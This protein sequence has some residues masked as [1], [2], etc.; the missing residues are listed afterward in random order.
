LQEL[1]KRKSEISVGQCCKL[2]LLYGRIGDQE[3]CLKYYAQ[4]KKGTD[5]E[6]WPVI[7]TIVPTVLQ[8]FASDRKGQ[9]EWLRQFFKDFPL[10]AELEPTLAPDWESIAE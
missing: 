6:T 8:S 10:Y 4:W 7:A 9:K 1:Q 2:V 3:M 5:E